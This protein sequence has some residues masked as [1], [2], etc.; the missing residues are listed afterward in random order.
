[1]ARAFDIIT[2]GGSAGSLQALMQILEALPEPPPVP[3]II[4][5]HRLRNA[6]SDMKRL[7]LPGYKIS[8]PEDKEPLKQHCI[9]LAPQ[10]YHLIIEADKSFMLDYSE[11][12][13]YSRPS[14]D[15]TFN[16]IAEVYGGRV[17]GILLSGS[18][19]DG[20]E[21]L[22]NIVAAGGT[23]IVQDPRTTEFSIMPEAA[24]NR[25]SGVK[26]MNI[27]QIRDMLLNEM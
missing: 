8:E 22:G 21:G 1:M 2:I 24:I 11:P 5:V 26:I 9:Y 4:V 10:N 14:I 20:A 15:V 16:S 3:V 25:C 6:K 17:L 18:N 27:P 13:H 12:V 7:L 23:G 19:R